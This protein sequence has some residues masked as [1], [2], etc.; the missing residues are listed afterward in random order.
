METP[1]TVPSLSLVPPPLPP[2]NVLM[3]GMEAREWKASA[4]ASS[5]RAKMRRMKGDGGVGMEV[6]EFAAS[7]KES[8]RSVPPT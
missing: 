6:E 1:L 8:S 3:E 2:K 7:L 4:A 5:E